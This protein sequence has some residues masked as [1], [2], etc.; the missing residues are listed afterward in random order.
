MSGDGAQGWGL[1]LSCQ[2]LVEEN[3]LPQC[4]L[5]S[6]APRCPVL[7]HESPVP[8]CALQLIVSQGSLAAAGE[9]C[10]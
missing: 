3:H 8:C 1:A 6:V 7:W 10:G 9:I 5:C 2:V 4:T